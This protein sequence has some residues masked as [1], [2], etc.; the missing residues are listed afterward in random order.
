MKHKRPRAARLAEKKQA[1][2]LNREQRRREKRS[3]ESLHQ[4]LR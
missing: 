4:G 1:K 2:Q 3:G